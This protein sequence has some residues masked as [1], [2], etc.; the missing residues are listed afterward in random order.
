MS[1]KESKKG[2]FMFDGCKISNMLIVFEDTKV[3]AKGA[4]AL[5]THAK[6]LTCPMAKLHFSQRK[7]CHRD[8][9][10]IKQSF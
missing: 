9:I 3:G 10:K 6:S 4:K 2:D 1:Y 7:G 5:L 8:K